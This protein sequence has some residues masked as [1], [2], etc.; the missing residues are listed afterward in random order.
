MMF[1]LNDSALKQFYKIKM[2]LQFA[3]ERIYWKNHPN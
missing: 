2:H 3:N 1:D